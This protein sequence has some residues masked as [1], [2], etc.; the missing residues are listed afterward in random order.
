M[1]GKHSCVVVIGSVCVC[2]FDKS[3]TINLSRADSTFKSLGFGTLVR[4]GRVA[5]AEYHV[6]ALIWRTPCESYF[7]GTGIFWGTPFQDI[8]YGCLTEGSSKGHYSVRLLK[9]GDSRLP[10]PC[11]LAVSWT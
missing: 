5:E 9:F 4:L 2:A 10:W 8:L 6:Y 1:F 7:D 3:D 11:G